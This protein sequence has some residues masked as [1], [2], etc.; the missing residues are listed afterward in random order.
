[1]RA[2]RLIT[3]TAALTCA[4][5]LT[6]CNAAPGRIFGSRDGSAGTPADP[7]RSGVPAAASNGPGGTLNLPPGIYLASFITLDVNTTDFP[8]P[9]A[10]GPNAGVFP[11]GE[12][13]FV[14]VNKWGGLAPGEHRVDI[15]I[16]A[17]DGQ[18]VLATDRT[19]FTVRPEQVFFTVAAPLRFTAASP[20][21]YQVAVTL[22]GQAVARYR[23]RVRDS[24]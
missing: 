21:Y 5:V 6:G 2:A 9:V 8:V 13:V 11:T 7:G 4:L 19:D 16:L 23:F 15:D 1:M 24:G 22:D 17:P 18:A 12:I 14:V 3:L 20:G 10:I